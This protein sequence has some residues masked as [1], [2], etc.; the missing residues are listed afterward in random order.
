V[1]PHPDI[2]RLDGKT[3]EFVDGSKVEVDLLVYATGY[4]VSVPFVHPDV[5]HWKDGYPDLI[6]GIFPQRH[7]NFYVM[8]IGQPRYGAG[9]LLTLG[10]EA[11]ARA[12][13]IQPKLQRPIGQVLQRMG[14]GPIDNYLMDPHAVMRNARKMIRSAK[15]LPLFERVL[16]L[17]NTPHAPGGPS[18]APSSPGA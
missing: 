2:K 11:L 18:S 16:F 12:I 1:T 6:Q 5:I 9:P 17:G 14:K 15:L 7:R 4:H 10:A 8:G 3:V 13:Q